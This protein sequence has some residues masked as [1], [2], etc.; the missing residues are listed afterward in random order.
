[1]DIPEVRYAKSGDVHIAYQ[2]VGEGPIDIIFGLPSITH[3]AIWWEEPKYA[4]LW[5]DMAS[6]ARVIL[7][8]KRG[9]GL[10]DR[11]VGI[12]T[13]E[14]R[15]DDFRAVMDA[16]HSKKAVLI[17]ASE[18]AAMSILFAA[19]HPE[20]AL[21][22][23]VI[24]GSA[25]ELRADDYP[26]GYT[27][28]QAEVEIRDVERN[29]G[30]QAFTDGWAAGIVPSRA[31]DAEFKRFWARLINFGGSP[32]SA[33]A[34]IKMN[35][36]IDVRS[37]LPTI[38]V[39]TLVLAGR[40][41]T[42]IEQGRYIADRIPGAK[43]IGLPVRDH[44]FVVDPEGTAVVIRAIH[45]FMKG[46]SP[47]VSEPQSTDAERVLTTVLFTDI[48]ESTRRATELGDYAWSKLLKEY[49][50]KAKTNIGRYRGRLIKSTG[51]GLL[52]IFDDPTRAVRCACNLRDDAHNL[53]LETRSGLHSGE[54][55][56]RDEDVEGI[57]VHIAARANEL[58]Q[59]GDV[60]VSSTVKDLSAGSEVK[61]AD[62][63]LNMM[64]GISGEWRTFAVENA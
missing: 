10:S 29:W 41:G 45:D 11:D 47:D 27:R 64:K 57:A 2:V 16:E 6:F 3:L 40:S 59:D 12:P 33:L 51:D 8:D 4:K 24:G 50:E 28:E 49:Q 19:A 38:H 1:M 55:V 15:M 62:R 48:V 30:K 23:I 53:G 63:G 44:Y 13:L 37:V 36:E 35:M 32:S 54:C 25:S 46:L 14:E 18:S 34:L 39:P 31:H 61:F 42:D 58:A 7:F 21:G 56:L 60:L 20:R 43:F 17:G 26:W 52:A 5:L 9:V 22:L